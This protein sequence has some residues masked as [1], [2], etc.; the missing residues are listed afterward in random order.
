[1]RHRSALAP[2]SGPSSGV[3]AGAPRPLRRARGRARGRQPSWP[4][5]RGIGWP[6]TRFFRRC[7]T[8]RTNR[9]LRRF[10]VFAEGAPPDRVDRRPPKAQAG[11]LEGFNLHASMGDRC[12]RRR[13]PRAAA[14]LR[15]AADGGGRAGERGRRRAHRVAAVDPRWARRDP[16]HRRSTGARARREARW[17]EVIGA[18]RLGH[19]DAAHV[20][21]GRARVPDDATGA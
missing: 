7:S 21:L 11:A 18:H 15:G 9:D 16:P 2:H 3:R 5:L 8:G 1:M 20:G 17:R 14:A 10:K 6:S 19:A 4:D 12:A 13:G